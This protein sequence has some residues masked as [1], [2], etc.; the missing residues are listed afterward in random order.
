MA[1]A[2]GEVVGVMGGRHLDAT[3]AELSINVLIGNDRNLAPP[4]AR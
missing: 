2:N 1:L 4:K 3:G